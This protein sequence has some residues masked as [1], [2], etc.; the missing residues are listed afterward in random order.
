MPRRKQYQES[1]ALAIA[2]FEQI[3]VTAFS[4]RYE[5]Q[6]VAGCGRRE[7]DWI[8]PE[9]G[10]RKRDPAILHYLFQ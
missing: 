3:G 7:K 6:W 8:H 1:V 2:H 9:P 4:G 5:V 10:F